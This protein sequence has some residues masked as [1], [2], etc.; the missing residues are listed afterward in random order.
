MVTNNYAPQP[1]RN[2]FGLESRVAGTEFNPG[3]G[4]DFHPTG[5]TVGR[6]TLEAVTAERFADSLHPTISPEQRVT[7]EA[8][9]LHMGKLVTSLRVA[10]VAKSRNPAA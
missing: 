3:D 10:E 9:V 8:A 4:I 6:R 1:E 7:W 5:A 2:A